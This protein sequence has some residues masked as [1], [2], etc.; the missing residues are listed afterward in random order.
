[1]KKI[2]LISVLAMCMTYALGASAAYE[3]Y[4]SIQGSKQGKFKGESTREAWKEWAP[5]VSIDFTAESAMDPARGMP[6]GRVQ[7]SP[8]T[9]IKE[10]GESSPQILQAIATNEVLKEVRFSFIHRT[11]DGVEEVY[12]TITLTNAMIVKHHIYV[13]LAT[14]AQ[15]ST[16]ATQELEDVSFVFER[17]TVENKISKI[18]TTIGAP[19]R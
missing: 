4:M 16:S 14:S 2:I 13:P 8:I 17:M 10:W 11:K 7:N 18:T 1:M 5:C 6:S 12:F 3:F 15:Q 9:I 19:G